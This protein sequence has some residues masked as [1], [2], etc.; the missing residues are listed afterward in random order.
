MD[1][2]FDAFGI[3]GKLLLA[4]LVNFGV[5]FVGLTY[6]LYKPVMKTLDE[7]RI[8]VA[9]G[10][11]DADQAAMKLATAATEAGTIVKHAS[12][13][14]EGIVSSARDAAGNTTTSSGVTVTVSNSGPPPGGSD[15]Q[16]RCAQTGVIICE[17]F[18]DASD[19]V[20]QTWPN[21]GL[22]KN[23]NGSGVVRGF[24]DFNVKASGNSSLRFDIHGNTEADHSGYWRQLLGTDFAEGETFYVQFSQR[25]S[26]EMLDI[27]WY[28][29]MGTYWKQIIIHPTSATCDD[30]AITQVNVYDNHTPILYTNCG[31][32]HLVT[33]NGVPPFLW[34]QGKFNCPYGHSSTDPNCY[35]YDPDLWVTYYYRIT[36]GTWGGQNSTVQ[37][38]IARNG[39][40]YEQFINMPNFRLENSAPQSNGYG[41]VTLTAY[42]TAKDGSVS[43]PTVSTWYDDLIVS[44]Q[45]ITAPGT[46]PPPTTLVGDLNN[47]RTVNG[48]DWGIMAS[49]W[50]TPLQPSDINNDGVVNS[51]DFSLMNANWGRTI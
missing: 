45:P 43:H 17:D 26:Q 3:D 29:L 10:V 4:Q 51:I 37:A 21:T 14:A 42:M 1:Q 20:T 39:Q 44:T 33:N 16:T 27:R 30:T 15:F 2:L 22:Y 35:F 50:F 28:S 34:Q 7:R 19:F 48:F 36:I 24:Q 11:I 6:L 31:A 25:I 38:Y 49:Q 18:D 41:V 46:T 47:D 32:R 5:L 23:G 9:Q 40:P 8:K 13:E 12:F